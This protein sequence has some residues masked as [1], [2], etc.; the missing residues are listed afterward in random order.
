LLQGV[1]ILFLQDTELPAGP[2]GMA[3]QFP[4]PIGGSA[5]G[6]AATPFAP[7]T[8]DEPRGLFDLPDEPLKEGEKTAQAVVATLTWLREEGVDVR[9]DAN[10]LGT[11]PEVFPR[12]RAALDERRIGVSQLRGVWVVPPFVLKDLGTE[13][14]WHALRGRIAPFLKNDYLARIDGELRTGDAID[15]GAMSLQAENVV[16]VKRAQPWAELALRLWRCVTWADTARLIRQTLLRREWLVENAAWL[17]PFR[18]GWLVAWAAAMALVVM[19]HSLTAAVAP[20]TW[21]DVLTLLLANLTVLVYAARGRAPVAS[22]LSDARKFKEAGS[23]RASRHCPPSCPPAHCLLRSSEL[24]RARGTLGVRTCS[25]AAHASG[26]VALRRGKLE[27]AVVQYEEGARAAAKLRPMWQ[28]NARARGAGRTLQAA[29]RNNA[30][31]VH[32]KQKE[33][34]KAADSCTQVRGRRGVRRRPRRR[35]A[36]SSVDPPPP[37]LSLLAPHTTGPVH[38][39][40]GRSAGTRQGALSARGRAAQA[41]RDGGGQGGP[42]RRI[43]PPPRRS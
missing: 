21:R 17:W 26:Q 35:L 4:G 2:P 8:R 16:V 9:C 27:A 7:R 36:R 42:A 22:A 10:V 32:L 31:I 19:A 6:V 39:R 41:G 38:F 18:W 24:P 28:L 14:R 15:W 37:A 11:V 29:C 3:A 1:H 34:E 5:D 23:V 13:V 25:A 43:P 33:W 40:G 12:F 30:A 20:T